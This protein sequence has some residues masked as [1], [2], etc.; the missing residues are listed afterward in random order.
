M[1]NESGMSGQVHRIIIKLKKS[2]RCVAH[3]DGKRSAYRVL[4]GK[5]EEKGS[6]TRTIYRWEDNINGS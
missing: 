2:D 1:D 4:V 6:L 5:P 3:V